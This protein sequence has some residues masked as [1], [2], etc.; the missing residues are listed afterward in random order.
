MAGETNKVKFGLSNVHIAKQ[1]EGEDGAITYD[2]PFPI[3]GGVTLSLDAS[4]DS[5]PFYADNIEIVGVA[6]K[7]IKDLR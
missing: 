4:G 6:V 7:V 1:I 5:N 2:E 3:P